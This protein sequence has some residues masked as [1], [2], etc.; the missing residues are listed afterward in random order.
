MHGSRLTAR[1][2]A[3]WTRSANRTQ[4]DEISSLARQAGLGDV[5][6]WAA[7]SAMGLTPTGLVEMLRTVATIREMDATG[8]AMPAR[9]LQQRMTLL[10]GLAANYAEPP[11]PAVTPSQ[12]SQRTRPIAARRLTNGAVTV[13]AAAPPPWNE[14]RINASIDKLA[15]DGGVTA[16]AVVELMKSYLRD[17]SMT[18]DQRA[19]SLGRTNQSVVSNTMGIRQ[20]LG[21]PSDNLRIGL[22]ER[23]G[24]PFSEV[25]ARIQVPGDAGL[26]GRVMNAINPSHREGVAQLLLKVQ[27]GSAPDVL[28]YRALDSIFRGGDPFASKV[29]LGKH[30]NL[31]AGKI[32][33]AIGFLNRTFVGE[34][35]AML[36]TMGFNYE[37]IMSMNPV[38]AEI[39][40]RLDPALGTYST[41]EIAARRAKNLPCTR[42]EA[43]ERLLRV[44][45]GNVDKIRSMSYRS[46]LTV[47]LVSD[48]PSSMPSDVSAAFD[49]VVPHATARAGERE[50]NT[51]FRI[52][53]VLLNREIPRGPR[54]DLQDRNYRAQINLLLLQTF[55]LGATRVGS[56]RLE[57]IATDFRV[58][59]WPS[60][61]ET[62]ERRGQRPTAG[63]T[64]GREATW[65]E[66]LPLLQRRS[67][68]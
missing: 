21:I 48:K 32:D 56:G 51:N 26:T 34:R 42:E 46:W 22:A 2:F 24:M 13:S 64:P 47:G 9:D 45:V 58:S 10:R 16:P 28:V 5:Q 66:L 55:G 29:A 20:M 18:V 25:A 60:P 41:T 3:H 17:P 19:A 67:V 30:L 12:Q 52:A 8:S 68:R 1:A 63:E 54:L 43:A 7:A 31:P 53:Q 15:K 14:Q 50:M 38:G 61:V 44:G 57:S 49:S 36:R 4:A 33:G 65:Q 35:I 62:T 37:Q 40:K 59:D 11:P 23:I 6:A 39:G 27:V